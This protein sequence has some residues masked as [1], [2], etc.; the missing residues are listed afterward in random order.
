MD[1]L[2]FLNVFYVFY[3]GMKTTIKLS[4][5]LRRFCSLFP[6]VSNNQVA[7]E[8]NPKAYTL[9][10]HITSMAGQPTPP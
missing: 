10:T 4:P 5:F 7:G 1:L 6:S 9:K 3:H 8:V 2:F